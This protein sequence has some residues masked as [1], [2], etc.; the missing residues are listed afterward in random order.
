MLE[1]A[2]LRSAVEYGIKLEQLSRS[3]L[4]AS[5]QPLSWPLFHA[6]L[7]QMMQL[8]IPFFE[9]QIDS[10]EIPLPCGMKP[11]AGFMKAGGVSAAQLRLR[12]LNQ[13]EIDFQQQLIRGA[14]SAR[15]LTANQANFKAAASDQPAVSHAGLIA[16]IYRQEA[17]RLGE[18]LWTTA[19]RDRKGRPEWLGIDLVAD[20]ES[21]F[22]GLIGPSLY[23]GFSGIALLFARMAVAAMDADSDKWRQRA[24]ACFEGLEELAMSSCIDKLFRMVRDLPYGISGIGGIILALELMDDAQLLEVSQLKSVLVQQLRP[25]RILLDEGV[26]VIGGVAGLIGPLLLQN[27]AQALALA[28]ACGDRLLSLQLDN[29]GWPSYW[30]KRN[31]RKRAWTGFS[32]G[33]AGMAAALA[34]LAQASG[35]ARFADAARRALA[36]EQR[37]FVSDQG[38]WPDF[39]RSDDPTHFMLSWCHGA[40]GILMSRLVIKATGIDDDQTA[41]EISAARIATVEAM[42]RLSSTGTETSSHICCGL[43]G[44]T[45]LLRVD[46]EISGVELDPRVNKAER[47]V[48]T[49]ALAIGAYTFSSVDTG[50]LDLPGLFTGK[51]GVA[52]SLL[53][54]VAGQRWMPHV[55]S[56]GL[57]PTCW[58]PNSI[59]D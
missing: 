59:A 42:I 15:H 38:N 55:L 41:G 12:N 35:E 45:S 23:S 19:I 16:N 51:A 57:L 36:Y 11:V 26:D 30:S 21:F 17:F 4:L 2:S 32:H 25:E 48:V 37:V 13:A 18:E 47:Q 46:A 34:R 22:F 49:R 10:Q 33:A 5:K 24:W 28:V 9:H 43:L 56:A 1:P 39:R 27:Q 29:G 31:G 3:Y 14:I 8:D 20:G 6:E 53:E 44:L 40:P 54:A 58:S 50:S 52:F 7:I